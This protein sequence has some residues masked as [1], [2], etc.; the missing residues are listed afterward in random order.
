MNTLV[1]F[2]YLSFKNLIFMNTYS[3]ESQSSAPKDLRPLEQTGRVWTRAAEA[4]RPLPR[5]LE[6]LPLRAGRSAAMK[7]YL[8]PGLDAALPLAEAVRLA[9]QAVPE[10][11]RWGGNLSVTTGYSVPPI[12]PPAR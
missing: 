11:E 12:L 8:P 9:T 7:P 4:E 1:C 2:R 6:E 5:R 3:R 10:V